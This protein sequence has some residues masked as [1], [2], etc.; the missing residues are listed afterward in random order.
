[1]ELINFSNGRTIAADL[2]E[3]YR[4]WPRFKGLMMTEQFPEGGALHL[5]PCPS[6]HTFF[7]K[8]AIDVLYL[9]EENGIVGLEENLEPGKLG[10]RFPGARSVIELPAGTIRR[11]S[12]A[13]GH[14]V[15]FAEGNKTQAGQPLTKQNTK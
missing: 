15:A 11:T 6:V 7:M 10:R 4:F 1:M 14:T 12:A 2:K 5:A 8:Y 13:V 9:N 3:A